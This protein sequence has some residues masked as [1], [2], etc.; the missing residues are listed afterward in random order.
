MLAVVWLLLL[1]RVR[2]ILILL[3][4][5]GIVKG[6][7]LLLLLIF[8]GIFSVAVNGLFLCWLN[9]RLLYGRPLLLLLLLSWVNWA[10]VLL[11]DHRRSLLSRGWL[12]SL[13]RRVL[14]AHGVSVGP[15]IVIHFGLLH[16]LV[17]CLVIR[18][19]D[20]TSETFLILGIVLTRS[21]RRNLGWVVNY[22]G[23]SRFSWWGLLSLRAHRWL[24]SES[25]I[26]LSRPLRLDISIMHDL[27]LFLSERSALSNSLVIYQ[28][29]FDI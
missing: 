9:W 12:R 15:H 18:V 16:R 21:K 14:V 13:F 20:N 7:R 27:K 4:I 24:R 25:K 10:L 3:L 29:H 19:M 5:L 1:L 6:I 8:K 23:S 26:I 22:R 2:L 17:H 28:A 11:L